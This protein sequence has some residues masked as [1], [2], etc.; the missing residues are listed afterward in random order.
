MMKTVWGNKNCY[1]LCFFWLVVSFGFVQAQE[2]KKLPNI[3]KIYL[4]TDRSKYF[5]GEDLWYK[6]Y[7][8][9]AYNNILSDNSNILYVELIA[10][11]SKIIARNKTNIEMGLGYGDFQLSDSL[12]V[13]PGM[14]QIRAYTNWDRNFGEDFI[15]TK[16]IE[17]MDAFELHFKP[18]TL[19]NRP[20]ENSETNRSGKK[21]VPE[22]TV[23]QPEFTVDF[24]PEGGSLLEN[25]AS[26]VGF[27]AVDS[28]G[29]PVT[30]KGEVFDSNNELITGFLSPHDGMGKLQMMPIEGKSYYAK[31]KN[32]TGTEIRVELPKALKQGYLLYLRAIK[33]RNIVTINTNEATLAQNP[34]SEVTLI[35]KSRGLSYLE[36]TQALAA[37][38]LSFELPKEKIPEG[39]SQL[40]LYDK[41]AR[42][43]SE[44]L[45]YVEKDNDLEV[46][47]TADKE[48]YRSNEKTT[49]Q[50]SSKSKTGE[51][52]SA[53][54]SLSVTD[55]NGL[56]EDKDYN[57]NIS[58]YFL[59][60]SDIRGRINNPGYY[61]DTANL[62]RLDYLDNLLLTQGW[63]DFMWKTIPGLGE[64]LTY[65]PEKGITISGR[66]K[67]LLGEKAKANSSMTLAL[68]NKKNFN[69]FDTVTDENGRFKFENIMFS[70]KTNMFLNTRNEKGKFRGEIILD[71]IEQVPMPVSFQKEPVRWSDASRFVAENVFK[72]NVAFG[73]N[74]ENILDEVKIT[75]TKKSKTFS[76]HGIPDFSYVVDEKS[77]VTNDIYNF[78]QYVIPGVITTGNSVRFMR[79][80]EP[81]LFILDG[82]PVINQTDIDIIQPSDIERIE[83][84]KGPGT[85]VYGSEGANGVIAIYTKP[86]AKNSTEKELF[87]SVKKEIEGYYTA[88]FFYT[89]NPEKPNPELDEKAAARNTIY[90]NPYV[91]P[92]KTGNVSVSFDNIAVETKVKVALEGI[93]AGG[94]PVVK[95][96]YYTITK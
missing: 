78:I 11:D 40:T 65:K 48:S 18:E 69:I 66:V 87:H 89:P 6:A 33:G 88:R 45:I 54:F 43:Q 9:L 85:V 80:D 36:T 30:V 21:T 56:V 81:A 75:G 94:I 32:L 38:S 5:T 28:Q 64:N 1:F 68:M 47:L 83:A 67:Q 16:D 41:E 77:P 37:T 86:G 14:Y 4:H 72:K 95:K 3:E 26:I 8:V 19:A 82:F 58:S 20:V 46:L 59:L 91:H 29:N 96:A 25:V 84:L 49:L 55:M 62:K 7:D 44:R 63:R 70:G 57:S 10:P 23:A 31:I 50:L 73:I 74:Q 2:V 27:K 52:R 24:F 12:G 61:F 15:F 35:C 92:D 79:F 22:K 90:W 42:P 60:E 34:N 17:I 71:A 53:S 39:I 51:A 93:T 76:L 13:K